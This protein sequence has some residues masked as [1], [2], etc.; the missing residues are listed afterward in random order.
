MVER[1]EEYEAI[2]THILQKEED[3]TQI[4]IYMYLSYFALLAIAQIWNSWVSLVSF[5]AL[6]VFQ[7]LVNRSQLAITKAAIF[8][9]IFFESCE[10]IHW[11]S[12]NRNSSFTRAHNA[13]NKNIGWYICKYG[14]TILGC[15]SLFYIALPA[16]NTYK[17]DL[18]M[19]P[20]NTTIQIYSALV[21]LCITIYVNH[22]Y[23]YVR[24]DSNPKIQALTVAIQQFHDE[25]LQQCSNKR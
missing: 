7:S 21:P 13:I 2:R 14:A 20:P 22:L 3:V 4:T 5:I 19:M 6:I 10:N 1:I 11:E 9:R 23:F 12:M 24:D 15:I 18:S 8:I 16:L 17:N 25:Q